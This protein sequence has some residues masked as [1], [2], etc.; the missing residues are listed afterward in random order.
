MIAVLL[1]VLLMVGGGMAADS[2]KVHITAC[3]CPIELQNDSVNCT[4]WCDCLNSENCIWLTS[5]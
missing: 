2:A 3:L 4:A 5:N 1:A